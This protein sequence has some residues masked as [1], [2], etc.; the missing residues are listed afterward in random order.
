MST[1]Q[2][3]QCGC[4]IHVNRREIHPCEYL[5]RNMLVANAE[6]VKAEA[7]YV[8]NRLRA[9]KRPPAW[10]MESAQ[11]IYDRVLPLPKELAEYRNQE[12]STDA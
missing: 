9:L 10:L 12:R 11:A 4:L 6:G 5:R 2:C 1:Y 8:L 3:E 7:R